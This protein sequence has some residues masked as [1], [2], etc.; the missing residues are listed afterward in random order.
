MNAKVLLRMSR[1]ATI[2]LSLAAGARDTPA[3]GQCRRLAAG[4]LSAALLAGLLVVPVEA[5]GAT[6]LAPAVAAE[7]TAPKA[8]APLTSTSPGTSTAPVAPPVLAGMARQRLRALAGTDS[9][10][11]R[12][13]L[14]A[15]RARLQ[16]GDGAATARDLRAYAARPL[17]GTAPVYATAVSPCARPVGRVR[18]VGPGDV[19]L[20]G[21]ARCTH[22]VWRMT[23]TGGSGHIGGM[24]LDSRQFSGWLQWDARGV[25]SKVS[26]GLPLQPRVV[27]SWKQSA[28]AYLRRSRGPWT[29]SVSVVQGT[30]TVG[31]LTMRGPL[32]PGNV[33]R[34]AATGRVRFATTSIP[35][36]G[37]YRSPSASG[38]APTWRITGAGSNVR[39]PGASVSAPSVRMTQAA[40]GV[41]ARGTVRIDAPTPV[42]F[43]ATILIRGPRTWALNVSGAGMPSSWTPASLPGASVGTGALTGGIRSSSAGV[44]WRLSAPLRL[45][46][47]RLTVQ[48]VLDV[49]G[50]A[51]WALRP[52]SATGRILD[53]DADLAFTGSGSV[54]V[55]HGRVSGSM[56]LRTEGEL[57]IGLPD[58]WI[59][60]TTYSLV[61]R[62]G[63]RI[64][65]THHASYAG[66]NGSTRFALIGDVDP[67][68]GPYFLIASG[69]FDVE[70]SGV[71]VRGEYMSKGW[72]RD[73][74]PLVKPFW[75][76]FADVSNAPGGSV[77]L[78]SGGALIGGRFGF[79]GYG[80]PDFLRA[81]V[82]PMAASS[83]LPSPTYTTTGIKGVVE[84]QPTSASSFSITSN[85]IYTDGNNWKLTVAADTNVKSWTPM[86]GLTFSESAFSGTV[87]D[88]SG[89]QTWNVAT[90]AVGWTTMTE[91][92]SMGA[93]PWTMT[94]TC[95]LGE[96]ICP[97]LDY[98]SV[99]MSE[100][101]GVVDFADLTPD[102]AVTGSFIADGDWSYFSGS[103]SGTVTYNTMELDGLS[104]TI[105]NGQQVTPPDGDMTLPDINGSDVDFEICGNFIIQIPVVIPTKVRGCA[106]WS[107]TGVILA[108]STTTG[109]FTT[110]PTNN[111]NIKKGSLTGYAWTNLPHAQSITID[112]QPMRIQPGKQYVLTAVVIP[113]RLMHDSG[114][115]TSLD[116]T[117]FMVGEF[118]PTDVN[119]SGSF[120]VDVTNGTFTVEA[121]S[122]DVHLDTKGLQEVEFGVDGGALVAGKEYQIDA[123]F[124]AETEESM[125]SISLT[126]KG[127]RT[128]DPLGGFEMANMIPSGD[129]EPQN[130]Q[131]VSS[132]L[133]GSQGPNAVTD[134]GFENGTQKLSLISNPGFEDGVEGNLVSDGGFESQSGRNL[135]DNADVEDTN[136]LRNGDFDTFVDQKA[137]PQGTLFGWTIDANFTSSVVADGGPGST[138]DNSVAAVKNSK[139][140]TA[141]GVSGL[142][143]VTPVPYTA[144]QKWRLTAYVKGLSGSGT[145][146]SSVY[147][148]GV[149]FCGAQT[150][151]VSTSASNTSWTKVTVDFPSSDSGAACTLDQLQ[152]VFD[153]LSPGFQVMVDSATLELVTPPGVNPSFTNLPSMLGRFDSALMSGAKSGVSWA[154]DAHGGGYAKSTGASSYYYIDGGSDGPGHTAGDFDSSIKLYF[155]P[156]SSADAAM[157]GFWLNPASST[158]TTMD[159]TAVGYGFRLVAGSG[160]PGFYQVKGS[161][162]NSALT[163]VSS[164]GS[165]LLSRSTWYRVRIVVVG[166]EATAWV[167][168]VSDGT[169]V[170]RQTVTLPSGFTAHGQSGQAIDKSGNG[171]GHL[172]DDFESSSQ[173]SSTVTAE[174]DPAWTH[175]HADGT[176]NN[177]YG[178]FNSRYTGAT[179]QYQVRESGISGTY[180]YSAWVRSAG[181]T[182]SANIVLDTED[183]DPAN[184]ESVSQAITVTPGWQ[185]VSVTLPITKAGHTALRPGFTGVPA[186]ETLQFDDQALT[187]LGWFPDPGTANGATVT[188]SPTAHTGT[189]SMAVIDHQNGTHVKYQSGPPIA[190][191][192]Y[193][194]SAWLASDSAY[195]GALGVAS[196]GSANSPFSLVAPVNGVLQ[197]K[198]VTVEY[199][200]GSSA[201]P[202]TLDIQTLT[203]NN[204][205]VLYVD[206]VS[207]TATSVTTYADGAAGN[208]PRPAGWSTGSGLPYVL[209]DPAGAHSGSGYMRVALANNTYAPATYI[210]Y[211]P[212]SAM[213]TGQVFTL[214]TWVKTPDSLGTTSTVKMQA[215]SSASGT[216]V[217]VACVSPSD[218]T[219]TQSLMTT[220]TQISIS[221]KLTAP[222]TYFYVQLG[223]NSVQQRIDV[224][225]VQLQTAGMNLADA[226]VVTASSTSTTPVVSGLTDASV[227]HSGT[228]YLSITG[229]GGPA[230]MY[231]DAPVS[232]S[233]G[234]ITF[235]D[236][237]FR[238]GGASAY[239]VRMKLIGYSKD[240]SGN[241]VQQAI[242]S[243]DVTAPQGAWGYQSISLSWP[244]TVTVVRTQF[245]TLGDGQTVLV[246]DVQSRQI[247]QW[248]SQ[249]SSSMDAF[250]VQNMDATQAASGAGY[251]TM[252]TFGTLASSDVGRPGAAITTTQSVSA[253]STYQ[254]QAYVRITPGHS[255]AANVRLGATFGTGTSAETVYQS[256]P[257]STGWQLITATVR[258]KSNHGSGPVATF[259][260]SD[261]RY[262]NPAPDPADSYIDVDEVRM[263]PQILSPDPS[264]SV[265]N[266]GGSSFA[267][268]N[269]DDRS[270]A[271]SSSMALAELTKSTSTGRA[272][273]INY[274]G[275]AVPK[276][277]DTYTASAWVRSPVPGTAIS[278]TVEV[279]GDGGTGEGNIVPF[280]APADG[281][282][283]LVTSQWTFT[284]NDHTAMHLAV[285]QNT[286]GQLDVDDVALSKLDWSTG[287]TGDSVSIQT[288]IHDAQGAQAGTNYL[289]LTNQGS[290]TASTQEKV[291]HDYGNATPL[292]PMVYLRSTSGDDVSVSIEVGP[293]GG[294][295]SYYPA[296]DQTYTIGKDWTQIAPAFTTGAA[297]SNIVMRVIL[298]TPNASVDIDSYSLGS[299]QSDPD[300]IVT[301]L[302]HPDWGWE[303][304]ADEPMGMPGLHLWAFTGQIQVNSDGLAGIGMSTTSYLDPTQM[305]S[306]FTGTAWMQ[307]LELTNVSDEDPCIA[308]KFDAGSS[309]SALQLQN[310]A[311][312]TT[313][314]YFYLAPAG[315]Q[316]GDVSIPRG[317][318]AGFKASL[319]D[320]TIRM[321]LQFGKDSKG[322][323]YFSGEA[324]MSSVKI[325][326]TE[327]DSL[328]LIASHTSSADALYFNADVIFPFG[329][330]FGRIDMDKSKS[331]ELSLEGIVHLRDW[332]LVGGGFDV[333]QLDIE[334]NDQVPFGGGC[335]FIKDSIDGDMSMAK[336]TSLS[337]SGEIET[338]CGVLSVLHMQYAYS[339]GGVTQTFA[340]DYDAST[341]HISGGVSFEFN[342]SF[343]WKF[344]TYRYHRHPKIYVSISYD[345]DVADPSKAAEAQIYGTVSVS[346]GSGSLACQLNST[347]D[348]S[349]H[350]T[351]DID[352]GVG[353][354][355]HYED[356]W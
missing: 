46:E 16:P 340:L 15:E 164:S 251:M 200:P 183:T 207:L 132:T 202:I 280:T 162:S 2:P 325:G 98:T 269:A 197:W 244:S 348:D 102:T 307:S 262:G 323:T 70:G 44:T 12:M 104:L 241:L 119:I 242:R 293:D 259:V 255:A 52:T 89:T 127:T 235:V 341:G 349:C 350:I 199:T 124:S 145:V 159:A 116:S 114:A 86:P 17:D 342:R 355:H 79:E 327:Y 249:A 296:K 28:R 68:G 178:S 347:G 107:D 179:A 117:F 62:A 272:G 80:A 93:V 101:G 10:S 94:N 345:M 133:D 105:S 248:N 151:S 72:L 246:D 276:A 195:S 182:F 304:L 275:G 301:Q 129:F 85:Y 257:L 281:T 233:A 144:G 64:G 141:A 322:K 238:S 37:W 13:I 326:G 352:A 181:D 273:L 346:G 305:P 317:L 282:W 110:N 172:W 14:A 25:T 354:G 247:A 264:W 140:A 142:R 298:T 97:V 190:G 309:G 230:V 113:G 167:Y 223:S 222:A 160:T 128:D 299:S 289:R 6:S 187:Q 185:Q 4:A 58:G 252:H 42:S 88:A 268:V 192:H 27:P 335:G 26:I 92:A 219:N 103:P 271:H 283:L 263:T 198:Q 122:V 147:A 91:G 108:Q 157:F 131:V 169:Q 213:L 205:K 156:S 334:I 239:D 306:L 337:F 96:S 81:A 225:D 31:L 277:G 149:Q 126:V 19:W 153:P 50:P 336:K 292:Y 57:L 313:L 36:I 7:A 1:A 176:A 234:T 33:Y 171:D 330:F 55:D 95:S 67:W 41:T 245:E 5:A 130:A 109:D 214:T 90:S 295:Y 48:G 196:G 333:D 311:L 328:D 329:R 177:L 287:A 224:D 59:T 303:Y 180:T 39:I 316:M 201:D 173:Q 65:F 118:T 75:E 43:P 136:V 208:L 8:V 170:Y 111:V 20:T 125:I 154:S 285:V 294:P 194:I 217:A 258:A 236:G 66:A 87:T 186:L 288:L 229:T 84:M 318:S 168:Q 209:T 291:V 163:T 204:G 260:A 74:S 146:Q 35:L 23:V 240:S 191:A 161:G 3:A 155:N 265:Y 143:Q 40:P 32:L 267:W 250:L 320:G 115:G 332:T 331:G 112:E 60:S 100:S 338:T 211:Q 83:S 82:A 188:T 54:V 319:G 53:V 343:S 34:L 152:V 139:S 189:A 71:P 351:V 203:G 73:G 218:A 135:L 221:C 47:G 226:W 165:G 256:F 61:P 158:S 11:D 148:G 69:S 297:Y 193:V 134:G 253:G 220:W 356:D 77:P 232:S 344:L 227:A 76:T 120:P 123:A 184:R 166:S 24:R 278:G 45:A 29:G 210:K 216:A 353:G 30:T 279:M 290:G 21:T 137:T 121:V 274:G 231:I 243:W 175:P 38:G 339:H 300:G 315:C 321:S 206:D 138:A 18:T 284:H 99:Y 215:Y 237:W 266:D 286:G 310:G 324:G 270:R 49:R 51:T 254:L 212:S 228:G 106:E 22:G 261:N 150:S 9:S 174:W 78:G 312:S 302:D 63:V 314:F 308:L 56:D